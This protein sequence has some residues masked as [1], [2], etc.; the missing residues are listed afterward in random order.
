MLIWRRFS[1]RIYARREAVCRRSG[2]VVVKIYRINAP[3][4]QGKPRYAHLG[5]CRLQDGVTAGV[6][7]H[8][9]TAV[10]IV[11]HIVC[12]VIERKIVH[13]I[14]KQSCRG[15]CL[16]LPVLTVCNTPRWLSDSVVGRCPIEL[17]ID[18]QLEIIIEG[19]EP[20]CLGEG[21]AVV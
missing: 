3:C 9:A 18:H 5:R 16:S 14:L 11:H 4:Q 8:R 15:V 10:H 1:L 20:S 7:G 21:I 12:R 17:A 6:G 13:G 2:M 19:S